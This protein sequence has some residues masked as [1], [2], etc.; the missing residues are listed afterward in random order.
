VA[1]NPPE[2]TGPDG[3]HQDEAPRH[4]G[5]ELPAWGHEH[6]EC[7]SDE[8][9]EHPKHLP[10]WGHEHPDHLQDGARETHQYQPD[11][12]HDHHRGQ[13]RDPV[14]GDRDEVQA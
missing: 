4:H 1:A 11:G 8:D 5:E 14:H 6:Q 7:L 9:Y 3:H 10:A 2:S 13:D 12:D